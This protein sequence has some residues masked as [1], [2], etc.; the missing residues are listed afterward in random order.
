VSDASSI[1]DGVAQGGATL[2]S[3]GGAGGAGTN[4]AS[5]GAGAQVVLNDDVGGMTSDG[6]LTLQ[7]TADGGAGGASA[8]GTAG[9]GGL[10]T[11]T[12]STT[13]ASSAVDNATTSATG[14][15]GGAGTSGSAGA[16]GG[17][18]TSSDMVTGPAS[19]T[20]AANATGGA[21][22]TGATQGLGGTAAATSM[23]TGAS[24]SS[25]ATAV[26]GLGA[27]G[28]GGATATA[29]G[30]STTAGG[31]VLSAS[32][33]SKAV[34]GNLVTLASAT[35]GE[36]FVSGN[37]RDETGASIGGVA[38]AFTSGHQALAIVTGEPS[39]ASLSALT[40]ANPHIAA[41]FSGNPTYFGLAEL[42]GSATSDVT[43]TQTI[44]DSTSLTVNL[45][46]LS[47]L[48][49][50]KLGLTDGTATGSG[51]ADLTLKVTANGTTELNQSFTGL[52]ALDNYFTDNAVDLGS[53]ASDGPTLTLGVSLTMT[54]TTAGSGFD[55]DLLAGQ[56]AT[57]FC[58]GTL[59]RTERGER[60]VEA[61]EIG[62]L[63]AT[64]CGRYRPIKWIG[65]RCYAGRFV[66]GRHLILPIC[67]RRSALDENVPT[68]DLWVSPGHGICLDGVLVPA[69]LLINGVSIA[70]SREV[71][72][73]TYFHVEL[74]DHE[75]IFAEGCP[76]ES[77][78]DEDCR[79]QFQNAAEYHL[80]YPE[81]R[82]GGLC[83]PRLEDG[84]HL[85]AIQRRLAARAGVQIP[86][87]RDGPLRGYVDQAGPKIVSGWAQC[88]SDPEAPI[89][90][91]ILV[92]G[93]RVMRLL[94]NRYRADLRD[95]GLGSGRHSFEALL[96][97]G[98]S[99]KVEVRR[100]S[101]LS[102]LEL[103]ETALALAA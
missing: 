69:W 60:P 89:R 13:D 53:L 77:F 83:L 37:G 22:G 55:F 33:T 64:T 96:P 71:D 58:P 100:S 10:A 87:E 38:P 28:G 62:D 44:K 8:G 73:V 25:T 42:G 5:G 41:G 97:A 23:G 30:D 86:A 95:A 39:A 24:V 4:G 50:L 93:K 92:E 40:S 98:V 70:Q 51:F 16:G 9:A 56:A 48:E 63:L 26:G 66:S 103:T 76:A 61:L 52:S 80:L 19:V 81:P 46:Q 90:L 17:A 35:A 45:G 15:K 88:E 29:S 101:D 91:D 18:A 54:E 36:T 49:D 82:A 32:S 43:G 59:I 2:T 7:Q 78:F 3:T 21:G 102:R 31:L 1:A 6:S 20:V 75:V 85:E 72:S 99:G 27:A 11:S 57:C 12:L 47:I 14:G 84:F 94:A 79:N 74:D 68:R 67:I 65:R 34:T